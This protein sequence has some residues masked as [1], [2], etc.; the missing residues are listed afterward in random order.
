MGSPLFSRPTLPPALLPREVAAFNLPARVG[1]LSGSSCVLGAGSA[2]PLG[3]FLDRQGVRSPCL[4]TITRPGLAERGSAEVIPQPGG[5]PSPAFQQ[6]TVMRGG[7]L[8]T[9]APLER[10][11]LALS[12]PLDR[13]DRLPADLYVGPRFNQPSAWA[14]KS[15]GLGDDGA[16]PEVGWVPLTNEEHP[17]LWQ[18]RGTLH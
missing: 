15:A 18:A 16:R 10:R 9:T 3:H 17:V 14:V 12:P 6:W 13:D 4:A 5:A 1:C 2:N 8:R 7:S 11:S